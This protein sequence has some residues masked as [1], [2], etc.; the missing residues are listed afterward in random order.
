MNKTLSSHFSSVFVQHYPFRLL[1][2]LEDQPQVHQE[3]MLH[4]SGVQC[5][6]SITTAQMHIY[7]TGIIH[8]MQ[9]CCYLYCYEC[10]AHCI[11]AMS[12]CYRY[13]IQTS[14]C[15]D[16]STVFHNTS[17]PHQ[18]LHIHSRDLKTQINAS[19]N[20]ACMYMTVLLLSCMCMTQ[21]LLSCM[22]VH[23]H[24]HVCA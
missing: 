7:L 10:A 23:A 22:C 4:V 14:T 6:V 2:P 13:L 17:L 16:M 5:Y 20:T 12:W 19:L 3:W 8:H 9:V 15:S 21:L 11:N 1:L 18:L 24:M